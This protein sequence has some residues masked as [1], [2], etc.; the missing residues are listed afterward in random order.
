MPYCEYCGA[1]IPEGQTVCLACGK[2]GKEQESGGNA[3]YEYAPKQNSSDELKRKLEE[4]RRKQ[5]E[6]SRR[7]AEAEYEQRQ[8][9]KAQQENFYGSS[10]S[11][12]RGT[13]RTNNPVQGTD[14]SR[15]FAAVSY[16]SALFVV[17][18]LCAKDDEFAIFHARQG[19]SLFV[20]VAVAELALSV[21]GLGWLAS[22]ARFYFM[23]LGI[24][25]ALNGRKE[26]LPYIGNLF[27]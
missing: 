7:W 20:A 10:V 3:A 21:V 26:R 13:E 19:M 15:I 6:Q 2:G 17:P 23:F 16:V 27:R 12:N 25:N 11:E 1:Y 4:Q 8:R 14:K 18:F 9:Q 22:I 24:R 5:Q